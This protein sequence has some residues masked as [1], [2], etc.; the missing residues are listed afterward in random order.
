MIREH[1]TLTYPDFD[2]AVN[3]QVSGPALDSHATDMQISLIL[4]FSQHILQY[5]D[6]ECIFQTLKM[7]WE[8]IANVFIWNMEYLFRQHISF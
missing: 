1:A 6:S 4:I 2:K 7:V 3:P 5:Y 8:T